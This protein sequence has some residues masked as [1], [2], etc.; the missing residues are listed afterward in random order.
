MSYLYNYIYQFNDLSDF[1]LIIAFIKHPI[2]P[3]Y[4]LRN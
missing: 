1:E 4:P 3:K 2:E